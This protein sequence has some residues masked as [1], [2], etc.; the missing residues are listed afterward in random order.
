MPTLP[1]SPDLRAR[2]PP[3]RLQAAEAL[4]SEQAAAVCSS[5]CHAVAVLAPD[6]QLRKMAVQL[7]LVS[8]ARAQAA[9]HA[10]VLALQAP[11]AHCQRSQCRLTGCG[12]TRADPAPPARRLFCRAAASRRR[13]APCA[14]CRWR[15]CGAWGRPCWS[16]P[17]GS[18]CWSAWARR[19]PTCVRLRPR[20]QQCW[21]LASAASL[22][23]PLR[24]AAACPA[25]RRFAPSPSSL[26]PAYPTCRPAPAPPQVLRRC[27]NSP[28]DYP[29][30]GPA[31][32]VKAVRQAFM[33]VFHG[34]DQ[35]ASAALRNCSAELLREVRPRGGVGAAACRAGQLCPAAGRPAAH[36]WWPSSWGRAAGVAGS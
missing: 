32:L 13:A 8:R 4:G 16:T 34:A 36:R 19:P 2:L 30:E 5:A 15:P 7:L 24:A 27:A 33:P 3:P 17:T 11:A 35:A 29:A 12:S 22:Q 14:A 20:A 9:G 31:T 21:R 1:A 18:C 25:W 23:P 26:P 28:S 10:S 6:D